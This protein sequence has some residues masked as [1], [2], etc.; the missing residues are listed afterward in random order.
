MLVVRFIIHRSVTLL[1]QVVSVVTVSSVMGSHA[2]SQNN[3]HGNYINRIIGRKK[4]CWIVLP[5]ENHLPL[6]TTSHQL[7]GTVK[8]KLDILNTDLHATLFL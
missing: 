1:D 4:C 6:P 5:R 2:A 8:E 3:K 7:S